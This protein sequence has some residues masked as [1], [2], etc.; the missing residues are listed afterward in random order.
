MRKVLS[1]VLVLSLVL[2]SFGFAFAAPM[3]DVAGTDY[4][5][6]VNVLTDLGVVDGYPDGTYKPA[7]IVTRAEMAK[8]VVTALGLED[9]AV[10][11][12]KFSD[13]AGNWA[14]KYVAYATSLG[15]IAGYPDGTFKPNAT[16]SYDEAATMLVAALGYTPDSLVGTWPANYVTKA[17]TLGVL[18]GVKSG[19]AGAIRG[20]IATMAYKTLG[21]SI[22]STDKDGVW[23]ASNLGTVL[24]PKADTML[25]RLGAKEYDNGKAFVLT[26][27][28]ADSA[29]ADV[30]GYVGAY[31][32]AYTNSDGDIIAITSEE[33]TFLTGKYN[34]S[35]K[36]FKVG[37]VEYN[38]TGGVT[39]TNAAGSSANALA[40]ANG[41]ATGTT[42]ASIDANTHTLA[43]KVSGKTIKEVYS[44]ATWSLT[45][46]NSGKISDADLDEL[47]LDNKLLGEK[48]K[49]DDNDKI[50]TSKFELLG[51]ASLNDIKVDN[52]VYVYT[53]GDYI[54]KV[55]VGTKVVTGVLTKI[56]TATDVEYTMGGTAYV[57]SAAANS[58]FTGL[59]VKNEVQAYL[60]YAGDLYYTKLVS[61]TSNYAVLIA[62]TA[63]NADPI[64]G[65]DAKVQ[66]FLADGTKKVFAVDYEKVTLGSDSKVSISNGAIVKYTLDSAGKINSV[67]MVND[68]IVN[69]NTSYDN[70]TANGYYNKVK[71]A[72]DAVIFTFDGTAVTNFYPTDTAVA[73]SKLGVTTLAKVLGTDNVMSIYDLNSDGLIAAMVMLGGSTSNSYALVTGQGQ[74]DSDANYYVDLLLDGKAVSY[75]SSISSAKNKETLYKVTFNAAGE[76]TALDVASTLTSVG[77]VSASATINIGVNG[78]VINLTG[79]ATTTSGS[80]AWNTDFT[81]DSDVVVY[82]Y[83]A[84]NSVYKVGSLSDVRGLAKEIFI[85]D[86]DTGTT[87][88]DGIYDVVMVKK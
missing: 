9:Y 8:I 71:F 11:T 47:K 51:V 83:D 76:V 65:D 62:K 48:F 25:Q 18:D 50:D 13:M 35:K 64:S 73:S 42:V 7:G 56:S 1:F 70:I 79:S 80:F 22:G 75:N 45:G 6:A 67:S 74:N 24:N 49:L 16:V 78:S 23:A 66:L 52:V 86:T 41:S 59:S 44:V 20:D 77:A 88:Q 43:V 29:V 26:S 87:S 85:F 46:G 81:L 14:D 17:K 2:G 63:R 82:V 55:E 53:T 10:G 4:E 72:S 28:L 84:D 58:S 69:T 32:K 12:S 5:D 3:S 15:I 54:S 21:L 31:V 40:V 30:R 68:T 39:Y 34:S 27:T 38:Y 19:A 57:K 37:S 61:G 36:V 60:D 33:S